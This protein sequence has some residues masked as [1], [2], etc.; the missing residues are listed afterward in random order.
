[1]FH[2]SYQPPN[3][4][5]STLYWKAWLLLLVVAAFNPQKI[6]EARY[7]AI[8][9]KL[10]MILAFHNNIL[11]ECHYIAVADVFRFGSVGWLPHS[12]NAH[13]DGYDKV[14]VLHIV[15]KCGFMV[16]SAC[17]TFFCSFLSNYS[18]PPCTVADEETKT[19]MIN[20]E[21]QM[22]QKERQ[23][24]LAF[25]SH[26]AAASTKQTITENNSLLLS[27]LTSLDPKYDFLFVTV[28][29]SSIYIYT[30]WFAIEEQS[31]LSKNQQYLSYSMAGL[32]DN[33]TTKLGCL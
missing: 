4:A 27:Q 18:Y 21:L 26:L 15:L 13:G 10:D 19:E 12:E 29:K 11:L 32:L 1:M 24:I 2:F 6:G 33:Y 8:S 31:N 22:S 28:V 23:E 25:E 30:M 5:I 17:D 3:L 16:I 9:Y 20:R 7:D 14:S